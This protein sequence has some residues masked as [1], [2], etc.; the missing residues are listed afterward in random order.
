[1]AAKKNN[2]V[3]GVGDPHC[4]SWKSQKSPQVAESFRGADRVVR[5]TLAGQDQHWDVKN[6]IERLILIPFI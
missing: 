5:V 6:L 4:G 1:M 2:M 3:G